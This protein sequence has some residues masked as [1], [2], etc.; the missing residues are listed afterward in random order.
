MILMRFSS[1]ALSGA[2]VLAV[3]VSAGPAL[4]GDPVKSKAEYHADLAEIEAQLL[5]RPTDVDLLCRHAELMGR[6]NRFE[7]EISDATKIINIKPKLRYGYLLKA[8]GHAKLNQN[9]AAI[10]S[11]NKAFEVGG[12][13]HSLLVLK[14]RLLRREKRYSEAIATVDQVINENPSDSSAYDCRAGCYYAQFGPCS[15]AVS[16]LEAVVRLNPSDSGAKALISEMS[17]KIAAQA[18]ARSK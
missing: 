10:E 14:A 5:K 11:L 2:I 13:T 6:L 9:L 4:C 7:E 17:R 16:D 15:E 18:A 8:Q 1:L 3:G 12:A